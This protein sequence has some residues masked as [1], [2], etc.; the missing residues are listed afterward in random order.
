MVES[1]VNHLSVDLSAQVSMI[2]SRVVETILPLS[3]RVC[4]IIS[5]TKVFLH[6][7]GGIGVAYSLTN[8]PLT[9]RP[10]TNL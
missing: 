5:L 6:G 9:K 10:L 7:L 1:V 3:S 8:W 4:L 2:L